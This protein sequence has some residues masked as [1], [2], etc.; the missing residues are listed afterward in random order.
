[1]KAWRC[2]KKK[3]SLDNYLLQTDP[4]DVRSRFGDLLRSYIEKK[5]ENP[6]W[7]PPYIP[8][9]RKY[10]KTQRVSD[11]RKNSV[12]WRPPETRY[13]DQTEYEFDRYDPNAP[14]RPEPFKKKDEKSVTEESE[15][16]KIER[17]LDINQNPALKEFYESIAKD[18][19]EIETEKKQ[20]ETTPK[21]KKGNRLYS[22]D[23]RKAAK[24]KSRQQEP[25]KEGLIMKKIRKKLLE[26]GGKDAKEKGKGKE[27]N[28]EKEKDK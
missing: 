25:K 13:T 14:P 23:K 10:W 6:E 12:T 24:E 28:K 5:K 11:E 22:K 26:L 9:T 3:G 16:D 27:K 1:M 15:P 8:R 21:L 20:Q 4:R 19:P 7:E 2:I 17:N 18:M